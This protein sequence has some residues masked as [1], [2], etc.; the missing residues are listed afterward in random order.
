MGQTVS[1]QYGG[2]YSPDPQMTYCPKC[3]QYTLTRVNYVMGPVAW[4]VVIVLTLT[5][6]VPKFK[7]KKY[8]LSPFVCC[9]FF[10]CIFLPFVTNCW[11]DAEHRCSVC[12]LYLGKFV[13]Q[14]ENR[15]YG[16]QRTVVV[17][18]PPI[19]P[20]QPP[21]PQVQPVILAS[22]PPM[23]TYTPP[24]SPPPYPPTS[25]PPYPR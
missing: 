20:R 17:H 18:Q 12:N 4:Y 16:G 21:Q 5:R 15:G 23:Q 9:L 1:H 2:I 10:P 11:R 8:F 19:P 6:Y 3:D 13:R 24:T 14:L 22:A 25:P 7:H